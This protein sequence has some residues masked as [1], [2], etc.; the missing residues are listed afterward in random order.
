M[1]P[2]LVRGGSS[3][4]VAK[5]RLFAQARGVLNVNVTF[6]LDFLTL[7]RSLRDLDL[8]PFVPFFSLGIRTRS[9]CSKVYVFCSPIE[10]DNFLCSRRRWRMLS[11]IMTP[12]FLIAMDRSHL[13]FL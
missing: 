6:S 9:T 5:C 3:G 8:A 11:F 1:A 12:F 10:T 4:D 2:V 13:E 7:A